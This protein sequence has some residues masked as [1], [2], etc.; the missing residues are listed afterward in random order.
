MTI[1]GVHSRN[2]IVLWRS[3]E[4]ISFLR[5][6]NNTRAFSFLFP[7]TTSRGTIRFH[8]G[9]T[10]AFSGEIGLCD[11]SGVS[12]FVIDSVKNKKAVASLSFRITR[13]LFERCLITE[14]AGD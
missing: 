10:V 3:L 4:T 9:N 8:A 14:N 1:T 6:C 7:Q 13:E 5:F 2:A 11:L 12:G